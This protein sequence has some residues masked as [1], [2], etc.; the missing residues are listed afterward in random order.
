TTN[1]FLGFNFESSLFQSVNPLCIVLFA[2]LF[3]MAWTWLAT[4]GREPSTPI[5]MTV[6]LLFEASAFA[7]LVP[8][9][10]L[11]LDGKVSPLWLTAAYSLQTL[12]ELC[13]S[14]VGLSMVTKLAPARFA[15]MLMGVWF[16]SNTFANKIAGLAGS[17]YETLSPLSLFTGVMW[18][19]LAGA[20]V[21]F[22]L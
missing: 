14:P 5:K 7:L 22:V 18:V 13:I 19:L 3:S 9:A 16:L 11:A 4:H 21:L 2:P 6:G 8:A 12:G 15:G 1:S 17:S 10:R 20:V